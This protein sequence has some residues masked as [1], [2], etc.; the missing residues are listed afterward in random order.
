MFNHVL[1][2]IA[3][4]IATITINHPEILNALELPTFRDIR[5]AFRKCDKQDD[6]K[7]VVVTGAGKAFSVGGNIKAMKQSIDTNEYIPLEEFWEYGEMT[8]A[9]KQCSKPIVAMVNGA[10]AGAGFSLA[11]ACDFRVASASTVFNTSFVNVTFSGD[12]GT[13]FL[14][15]EMLGLGKMQELLM[16]GEKVTAEEADKYGLLTKLVPDEEL[17]AAA[18]KLAKR[19]AMGPTGT[20]AKQKQLIWNTFFS[21]QYPYYAEM[22][23]RYMAEL[24][25]RDDYTEAVTAFLEKRKP[26]FIGS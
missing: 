11:L 26:N 6:V 4:N 1:F 7:A 19:L 23:A 14:L 20:Y 3:D 13:P 22:E 21:Q 17:E 18:Y 8:T 16:L 5:D 12:S 24:M 25:R 15:R 9:A 10:C 2:D